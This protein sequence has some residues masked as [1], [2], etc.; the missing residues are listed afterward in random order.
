MQQECLFQYLEFNMSLAVEMKTLRPEL[1]YKLIYKPFYCNFEESRK[2]K[3]LKN[4]F[5]CYPRTLNI[6]CLAEKLILY[7]RFCLCIFESDTVK[8]DCPVQFFK[9]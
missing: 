8:S 3:Y 5:L 1:F 4:Y 2:K 9:K 7:F 6:I